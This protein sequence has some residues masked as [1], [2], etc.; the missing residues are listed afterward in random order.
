M[1]IDSRLTIQ[2][3]FFSLLNLIGLGSQQTILQKNYNL[4]W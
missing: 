2:E 4:K 1:K 3:L